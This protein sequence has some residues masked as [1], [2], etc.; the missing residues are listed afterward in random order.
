MSDVY[1]SF[2]EGV[3]LDND[4][5]MQQGR[6]KIW[7]P[8][9]DGDQVNIETLPWATYL[10]PLAGQTQS[11]PAG[12][13]GGA[14]IGAVA[15]GFWSVPKVGALVIV[16]FLYGDPNQR[17]YIGSVFREFG[18]RSLPA[19]RNS[20]GAPTSDSLEDLEPTKTNMDAQFM[21]KVTSPQARTR[22]AY[23]RQ[24][25]QAV[26]D[27]D[28]KE[29]YSKR[30]T[31]PGEIEAGD[32]DPQTSC[33]TTP[34]RHAIIMQDDPHF[35]RVRIKTAEGAQIILDDAN[36]RIYISTSRGRTWLE[37]DLD[38]HIH[39]YGAASVSVS[40]GADLNLQAVK[41]INIAA[42]ADVNIVSAGKTRISACDAL[43]VSGKGVNLSSSTQMDILA[44][45]YIMQSAAQIHLNGPDADPA[46]LPG[47]PSITPHHE[48][49]VR[50]ASAIPRGKYWKE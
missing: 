2:I 9:I 42:G 37:M 18:N 40:A 11:Y 49:F 33:W 3:V 22:G 46:E 12:S 30:L 44:S 6:L 31:P 5:P 8:A 28:G 29:G 38:G 24:V 16:G 1:S 34:G 48:P 35:A 32:L 25:A 43:H 36:E 27:K 15:Y 23:E 26:T 20:D 14:A 13:S 7:C 21:G 45:S 4:D 10:T 17:L 19:G 41:N 39:M 50:P 47:V